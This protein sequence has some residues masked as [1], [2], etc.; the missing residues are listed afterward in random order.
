L[1]KAL[2]ARGVKPGDR[3]GTLAW[4]GYRHLEIYYGVSGQGAVC[5]TINPRLFEHQ[6]DFIVNHAEDRYLF[7]DLTFVP[8]IEKIQDKLSGVEGF[9]IMTDESHMPKTSLR[10]VICYET[11]L[12]EQDDDYEWPIFDENLASSLCY[13]S[14]TT[15]DPKGVLYTHRA[16]AIHSL[17]C[18]GPDTFGISSRDSVLPVVPMFHVNSW[19]IPY[20]APMVGAKLVFPGAAMDGKSLYELMST[21]AVT[22]TAGVPTV[23]LMLLDYLEKNDKTLPSLQRVVVGGAACPKSMFERFE[24]FGI[25]AIHAW[26]MTEM[27]PVGTFNSLK[28]G[29]E[30]LGPEVIRNTKLKQGRPMFCVELKITDEKNGELPHDGTTPGKLK[31]RGPWIVKSY[32]KR[33]AE[34]ILDAD[35]WFDTGDI[36]TID[37]DGFMQITD[38][39]KDVIKSGGEWISSVEL[40]NVAVGHP[41]VAEAAV[42]GVPHPK[43]DERPLLVIVAKDGTTITGDEILAYMKDK[44]AKWWLPEDVVF[45][46]EIPHTGTG[47]ILK[48]KLR[49]QFKEFQNI[50]TH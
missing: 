17:S 28:G 19:T 20:I 39:S 5:H 44:V 4:N 8:L 35:G 30:A 12:A 33:E 1:A 36:S 49:E 13:T 6:I 37:S 31:V 38:R 47:K 3:L 34:P 45:V 29:M 9:I 24:N 15:G 40:E 23:W 26:G 10:D 48:T 41:D 14:G 43:W 18:N 7:I 25:S 22:L 11:F 2:I 21:E 46:D 27:S 42:I 50:A 16:L 32:F